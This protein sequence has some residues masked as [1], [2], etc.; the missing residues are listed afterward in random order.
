MIAFRVSGSSV[1]IGLSSRASNCGLIPH[2]GPSTSSCRTKS[3]E[4]KKITTSAPTVCA[5]A[6]QVAGT[7]RRGVS[8]S[9]SS[10]ESSPPSPPRI[11]FEK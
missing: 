7:A 5:M 9:G 6:A 1:A 8:F 2:S 3:R 11:S 4:A 10:S